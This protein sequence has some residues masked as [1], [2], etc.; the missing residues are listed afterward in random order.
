MVADPEESLHDPRLA[1]DDP[2][3]SR[4]GEV[5]EG[6]S[7]AKQ[8]YLFALS[9]RFV[10]RLGERFPGLLEGAMLEAVSPASD[11]LAQLASKAASDFAAARIP[12]QE[13][14]VARSS[15]CKTAPIFA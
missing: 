10:R 11:R 3:A 15:R 4:D 13:L 9:E 2:R 1:V 7:L 12:C 5:A 14:R 6:L 8:G